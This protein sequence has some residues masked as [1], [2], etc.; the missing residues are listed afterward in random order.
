MHNFE[1]EI[2]VQAC[3]VSYVDRRTWGHEDRG[4]GQHVVTGTK[5]QENRTGRIIHWQFCIPIDVNMLHPIIIV[6]QLLYS[7]VNAQIVP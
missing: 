4:P 7:A 5:E 3:N 2:D 6:L 1:T